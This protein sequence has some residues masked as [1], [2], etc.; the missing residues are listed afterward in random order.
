MSVKK[1]L[2]NAVSSACEADEVDA[3]FA[4]AK[5]KAAEEAAGGFFLEQ[6]ELLPQGVEGDDDDYMY[7]DDVPHGYI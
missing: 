3:A 5:M 6:R 2:A 1:D 4:A 7:D